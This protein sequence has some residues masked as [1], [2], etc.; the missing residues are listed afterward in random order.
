MFVEI[1]GGDKMCENA[2]KC[3]NC[4][5]RS[6][7]LVLTIVQEGVISK[8]KWLCEQCEKKNKKAIS[9]F[10]EICEDDEIEETH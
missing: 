9:K 7:V 10:I 6:R 3:E 4:G 5:S 2:R 8:A 1:V